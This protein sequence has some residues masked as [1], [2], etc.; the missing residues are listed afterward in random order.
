[1]HPFPVDT[2]VRLQRLV[3]CE[4]IAFSELDRLRKRDLG[5]VVTPD[6]DND[7][8][9]RSYWE[10]RH[11]YASCLYQDE[12]RDFRATRLSDFISTPALGRLAIY[13]DFFRPLRIEY[14]LTVGLD[15]PLT[16]TKV[17]LFNR[18]K[19]RD[20]SDRDRA[21]MD[22]LRP[23]L[24]RIYTAAEERRRLREALA[25]VQG[26]AVTLDTTL[27]AREQEVLELVREGKTNAEV[28]ASLWISPGTVRRHLENVYAKLGVHTRTGAV[29]RVRAN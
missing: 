29:A 4:R 13:A 25:A 8:R 21:V 12:T 1:M 14:Q 5:E 2:L 11:E 22:V 15:A 17:F 18:P 3:P 7:P 20:F 28:A 23:H 10:V 27:T 24:A 26:K 16:H 19:G 9:V 6:Y